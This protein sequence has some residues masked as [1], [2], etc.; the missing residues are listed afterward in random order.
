MIYNFFSSACRKSQWQYK[1]DATMG[2]DG[3]KSQPWCEPALTRLVFLSQTS[4]PNMLIIFSFSNSSFYA[5]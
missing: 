2:L 4:N 3:F 1:A 5:A